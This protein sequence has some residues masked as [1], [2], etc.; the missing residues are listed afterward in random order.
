[1]LVNSNPHKVSGRFEIESSEGDYEFPNL[2]VNQGYEAVYAYPLGQ[3][4]NDLR[5]GPSGTTPALTD[6]TINAYAPIVPNAFGTTAIAAG[7]P[8]IIN[9]TAV[10]EFTNASFTTYGVRELA[11]YNTLMNKMIIRTLA[12]D[13]NNAPTLIN[14]PAKGYMRANY[15]FNITRIPSDT[16]GT[17]TYNSVTY[18][19]RYVDGLVRPSPTQHISQATNRVGVDAISD[20]QM[21]GL[22]AAAI[23]ANI[24][25][26]YTRGLDA[27]NHFEFD[28]TDLTGVSAGL[29][30]ADRV[31]THQY[32]RFNTTTVRTGCQ[33]PAGTGQYAN[34]IA[35]MF[36]GLYSSPGFRHRTGAV[37][38]NP[39]LPKTLTQ[40]FKF[41][42]FIWS[43]L[44]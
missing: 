31:A 11:L 7:T 12:R 24:D 26:I 39:P 8:N 6:T 4:I 17:F 9:C 34:G 23:Q 10:Y 22:S 33:I 43:A 25:V 3:F 44:T 21:F 2:L 16:S 19:W 15:K 36:C 41:D 38:I 35:T 42:N 20:I 27:A 32:S 30:T 18:N 5:F 37:L 1:M 29:Y 14:I 28:I 40:E 13:S